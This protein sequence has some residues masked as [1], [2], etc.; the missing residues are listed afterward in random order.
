M[1]SSSHSSSL[2]T[3]SQTMVRVAPITTYMAQRQTNST[4]HNLSNTATNS[5]LG[6]EDQS[7][8]RTSNTSDHGDLSAGTFQINSGRDWEATSRPD[9]DVVGTG[10]RENSWLSD[11]YL[12][13]L[14][15]GD[16][17]FV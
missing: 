3:M 10:R 17:L 6:N 7:G 8:R 4:L 1:G 14:G 15:A 11:L 16:Y 5:D 9:G 2:P 12:K 13:H